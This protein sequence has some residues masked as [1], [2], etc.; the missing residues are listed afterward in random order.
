MRSLLLV[1][2]LVGGLTAAMPA[3]RAD[4]AAET[5]LQRTLDTPINLD[6]EKVD[7]PKAFDAIASRAKIRIQVDQGCYD[8]LPYG[9][10]TKVTI[11]FDRSPLRAGRRKGLAKRCI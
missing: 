10:T 2:A 11:K 9:D 3:L 8:A 7:L 6:L 1:L 4:S 5:A